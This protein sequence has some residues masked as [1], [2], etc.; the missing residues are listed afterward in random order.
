MGSATSIALLNESAAG[1]AEAIWRASWQG[2]ALAAALAL[3]LR[4]ICCRWRHFPSAWSCRLWWLVCLKLLVGLCPIFLALPLI[5]AHSGTGAMT[6]MNAARP[7]RNPAAVSH[8]VGPLEVSLPRAEIEL[9]PTVPL[10]SVCSWLF[11]GWIAGAC[12]LGLATAL[13]FYRLHKIVRSSTPVSD[14][15]IVKIARHCSEALSLRSVPRI[16]LTSDDLGVLTFGIWSPVVLVSRQTLACCS[17]SELRMVLF[18]EFSHV[19][20]RDIRLGLAPQLTQVLFWF[21]PLAWLASREF[22]LAREAACDEQTLVALRSPAEVYARLLLKLGARHSPWI[23]LCA[24]GVSSHFRL[25]HRRISMLQHVTEGSPR[26]V[27]RGII[28]LSCVVGTALIVPWTIVSAQN[29]DQK[30]AG[31]TSGTIGRTDVP[32]RVVHGSAAAASATVRSSGLKQS[33]AESKGGAQSRGI[34]AGLPSTSS[35]KTDPKGSH[36]AALATSMT[37]SRLTL[38]GSPTTTLDFTTSVARPESEL[39]TRIF[40]LNYAQPDDITKTLSTLFEGE[41]GKTFR[42]VPDPRTKSIILR[43]GPEKT[44]EIALILRELDVEQADVVQAERIRIVPL[45]F[46]EAAEV[47]KT[48][49]TLFA[50]QAPSNVKIVPIERT[51]SL[52]IQSSNSKL[53]EIMDVFHRLD[54]RK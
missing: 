37:A 12:A 31:A 14:P 22:C 16:L 8:V 42:L 47:A 51:N 40:R 4:A 52:I 6:R 54:V 15:D 24:P 17:P 34:P 23:P 35:V 45:Q 43:A 48:L 39:K 18:H 9:A 50:E 36:R 27:R 49:N 53:A 5:P 2:G 10:L 41:M 3:A 13:S 46:A 26:R 30:P 44:E 29:S 1:W 25:L 21:H 20:R 33:T 11:A 7:G 38:A 28:L 32:E 19:R